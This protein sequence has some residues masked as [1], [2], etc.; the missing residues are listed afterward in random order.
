[1]KHSA[2]MTPPP[3]HINGQGN[4]EL[5][6][7]APETTLSYCHLSHSVSS[8]LDSS[9]ESSETGQDVPLTRKERQQILKGIHNI[10]VK[11]ACRRSK[12][13]EVDAL[14]LPPP[15]SPLDPKK[16]KS[17]LSLSEA[18]PRGL[19]LLR[20]RQP[21]PELRHATSDENLSSSTGE[22]PGSQGTWTRTRNRQPAPKNPNPTLRE[23]DFEARRRKRRSRSFEVTGQALSQSKTMAAQR[24]RP[25]DST[26]DPHLHINGQPQAPLQRP[27]HR[28]VPPL[29][30]ARLPHNNHQTGPIT[31]SSP[32]HLSNLKRA[33]Q[34]RQPQPLLYVTTTGTGGQ[35][36]RR[37]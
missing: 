14:R 6:P 9:P 16:H 22:G 7:L 29:T 8:H 30:K 28:G 20:G 26:S 34:L 31:E 4:R 11:A 10:A 33:S 17:S 35:R 13:L 36:T 3:I 21:S 25:L 24:V 32:V 5:Q 27:Q 2:V 37:H 15:P 12:A 18:P 1:M 23:Q 19:A